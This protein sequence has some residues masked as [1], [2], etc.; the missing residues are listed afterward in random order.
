MA[1]E[2]EPAKVQE[3]LSGAVSSIKDFSDI[4]NHTFPDVEETLENLKVGPH[5]IL[6][7]LS[8]QGFSKGRDWGG[9][10]FPVFPIKVSTGII[11]IWKD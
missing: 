1:Q 8:Q 3:E 10:G 4:T 9:G 7:P 6:T 5:R 11:G 2:L